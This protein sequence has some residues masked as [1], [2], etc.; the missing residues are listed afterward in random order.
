MVTVANFVDRAVHITKDIKATTGPKLKDF[1]A[2]LAGGADAFPD[3]KA[4]ADEVAAFS[5]TFPNI[6]YD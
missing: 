5:N 3:L 1:K 4:L 2:A 6:G